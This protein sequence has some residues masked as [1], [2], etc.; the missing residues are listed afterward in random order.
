MGNNPLLKWLII[1]IAL[2]VI[3]TIIIALLIDK[4]LYSSTLKTSDFEQN[5]Y[6]GISVE[7]LVTKVGLPEQIL[8]Y[9]GYE[10][11]GYT[12]EP[13][14]SVHPWCMIRLEDSTVVEIY[15]ENI[16][17]EDSSI[18]EINFDTLFISKLAR[19]FQNE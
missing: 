19:E 10:G 7:N 6:L 3:Q 13:L 18:T 1:L 11:W 5:V 2:V 17:L 12:V 9:R 8:R 16:N 15:T 14:A 4:M